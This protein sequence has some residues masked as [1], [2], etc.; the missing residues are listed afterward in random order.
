[1]K[2]RNIGEKGRRERLLGTEL[3][4]RESRRKGGGNRSCEKEGEI[5][6]V[7]EI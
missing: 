1:M 6:H 3:V 7:K 4:K 2:R 5:D